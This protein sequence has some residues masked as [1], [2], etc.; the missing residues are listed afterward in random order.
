[1]ADLPLD[2]RGR[3]R[4]ATEK[5][6]GADGVFQLELRDLSGRIVRRKGLL[7]QAKNRWRRTSKKLREQAAVL[8]K[9]PGTGL[10]IFTREFV[11]LRVHV[12]GLVESGGNR[13]MDRRPRAQ[14]PALPVQFPGGCAVCCAAARLSHCAWSW[15]EIADPAPKSI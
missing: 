14:A 3:G 6:T 7:F 15:G 1:M 9:E 10:F 5:I 4:G 2:V 13:T 11:R 8:A 12:S